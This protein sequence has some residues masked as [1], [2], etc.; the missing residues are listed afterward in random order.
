MVDL[1]ESETGSLPEDEVTERPV[2]YKTAKENTV[3]PVLQT[4]CEVQKLKNRMV[5]QSIHVSSHSFIIWKQ[6]SR[7]SGISADE[8][9]MTLWM[10]WT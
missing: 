4:S 9:M 10:I 7:S 2:P 5:T 6:S 3:H 1:S 8:N